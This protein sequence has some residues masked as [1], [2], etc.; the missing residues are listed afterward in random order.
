MGSWPPERAFGR[1]YVKS[2]AVD[3]VLRA[4]SLQVS[5]KST[6]VD[7][8]GSARA[9]VRPTSHAPLASRAPPHSA[10]QSATELRASGPQGPR[11]LE[12]LSKSANLALPGLARS[13]LA[14]ICNTPP[15]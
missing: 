10:E 1:A 4:G 2:T 8:L 13:Q 11:G 7:T 5:A 3:K 15:F 6:A 9:S 14:E 12:G